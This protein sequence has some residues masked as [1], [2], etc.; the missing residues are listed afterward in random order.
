MSLSDEI[1]SAIMARSDLKPKIK[2]G[3]KLYFRCFRHD[4]NTPSAWMLGGAHGCFS[5][6]F[7][8][9]IVTLAP[10]V[11]VE[12]RGNADYTLE[13]YADS[14]GFS[15]SDLRGW[16][17]ETSLY[18]GRTVV[19]IPY[20]DQDGKETRARFRARSGKWW[21][22]RN[23]PI[24]LYGPDKL[25]DAEIGDPVVIVEGESDCH[26]F[27]SEGMLAVGVPG[28]TTWKPEWASFVDGLDV[29][30]WEEPDQGGAQ[31]SERICATLP[32]AKVIR[33]EA[34]KDASD[35]RALSNGD[36]K[37]RVGVLMAEAVP[38]GVKLPDV[39]FDVFQGARIDELLRHQLTPVEAIPTPFPL[40]NA[41]CRD[42]GGGVGLAR[43]WNVMGAARTG[44]GK[45][46]LALNIAARAMRA[47]ERV[48]FL[49]LEMSQR[50]VETRL[51]AI[52]SGQP[53][54]TLEKGRLFDRASFSKAA[55]L[56]TE[57]R[58]DRGGSFMTN[59]T[60]LYSGPD[61]VDSMRAM[62]EIHG[63]R[64]FL[65]DYMQLAGDQNDP[66]SITAI[67]RMV[68]ACTRDLCVTTFALSQLNRS[69]SMLDETPSVDGLMG[70]SS[71]GNDADQ[72]VIIDH[73][74]IEKDRHGW[75]SELVLCKNRHG[76]TGAIGIHFS[77]TTLQMRE[78]MDNE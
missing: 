41:M 58:K 54:V 77:S 60:P 33:C 11:G 20:H 2:H 21:E 32:H 44:T 42:E 74:K 75:N 10:Y 28:A 50:Q 62:H 40:W 72:V 53:V 34:A 43:G 76:G 4:D 57:M 31:M 16:G 6:G 36:F 61:L 78:L 12:T 45:S 9:S 39:T 7:E 35:L 63:A 13:E 5:C 65:V 26:A 48:C 55:N 1:K 24:Y 67:S 15:A 38:F 8:E 56:F 30:V 22:G 47:G 37:D 64:F 3:D 17:C 59:R 14:K 18:D 71:L 19:R 66:S 27:W 49:S 51:M 29:Y 73:S 69:A 68:R 70:T 46:I 25:T 52:V 23:L